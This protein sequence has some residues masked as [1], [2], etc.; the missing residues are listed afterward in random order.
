MERMSVARSTDIA[1]L[2]ST[3]FAVVWIFVLPRHAAG[4]EPKCG[5]V[6]NEFFRD[7]ERARFRSAAE[8]FTFPSSLSPEEVETRT[9]W[10]TTGFG[11]LISELG[12]PSDWT[13]QTTKDDHGRHELSMHNDLG[14]DFKG[15]AF[16]VYSV[17]FHHE[18]LLS[19][20]F[21]FDQ[22]I[23]QCELGSIFMAWP[24]GEG[25]F[26]RAMRV[27]TAMMEDQEAADASE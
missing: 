16:Y 21:R 25:A 13:Y 27:M 11:T 6:V 14:Q 8:T 4:E 18:G 12:Y 5:S 7:L 19:L 26:R 2:V 23:P 9:R 1:R 17:R 24:E 15:D 10:H 22:E 3:L 20:I